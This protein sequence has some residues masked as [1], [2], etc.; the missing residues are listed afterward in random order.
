MTASIIQFPVDR[1]RQVLTADETVQSHFKACRD[2]FELASAEHRE[3]PGDGSAVVPMMMLACEGACLS[4]RSDAARWLLI[5][6]NVKV[7]A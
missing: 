3:R 6:C 2:I 5:N 1:C 7:T 4:T